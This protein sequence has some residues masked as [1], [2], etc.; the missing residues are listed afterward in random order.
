[1][2]GKY[3]SLKKGKKN[4]YVSWIPRCNN[5]CKSFLK[6]SLF[7]EYFREKIILLPKFYP[8]RLRALVWYEK[9]TLFLLKYK[10][11][12]FPKMFSTCIDIDKTSLPIK[13][14]E[15]SNKITMC[16]TFLGTT[17]HI[18]ILHASKTQLKLQIFFVCLWY[19][20][21]LENFSLI[22]RHHHCRWRS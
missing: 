17:N 3:L 7:W 14:K 5:F 13:Y 2:S 22:W 8:W 1:M 19:Y 4:L 11:I 18:K 9:T 16:K 10:N 12:C 20:V 15:V 21:L 6:N